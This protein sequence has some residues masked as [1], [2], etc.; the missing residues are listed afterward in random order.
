MK[1]RVTYTAAQCRNLLANAL[2]GNVQD[3]TAGCKNHDGGLNQSDIYQSPNHVAVHKVACW[4]QYFATSLTL[5]GTEDERRE[6]TFEGHAD[7]TGEDAFCE[8]AIQT[9]E[10][11]V[12]VAESHV[13][14]NGSMESIEDADAFVNFANANF[15][16]GCFIPSCTQEEI[17]QTCCPEFNVG[18]LHLGCMNQNEVVKVHGVRRFCEYSGYGFS[19]TFGGPSTKKTLVQTILTMDAVT[20]G[21][22]R[23]ECNL[24]DIRKAYLSFK[25]CDVVSTGRWGCGAFGGQPA[26]KFAQQLVAAMLADCSLRFSTFGTPEGCDDVLAIVTREK[27]T[28]ARLLNAVLMASAGRLAGKGTF[29]EC[30]TTMLQEAGE[31]E[32]VNPSG[33]GRDFAEMV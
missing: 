19:F 6:V 12:C 1:K 5:E 17:I 18:M 33:V 21:H 10:S 15:G 32:S 14:H 13:L 2:L 16:F 25:G 26:H 30:L 27:P 3:T 28:A 4:L 9:G 8:W 29:T 22:F 7:H 23:K 31:S 24:R 20:Q 11:K